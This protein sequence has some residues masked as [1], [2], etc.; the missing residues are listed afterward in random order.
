MYM[1][2]KGASVRTKVRVR[3]PLP[4]AFPHEAEREAQALLAREA[5]IMERESAAGG[6]R[7]FR[8][9]PTITIDPKSAKDFDDAISLR[10]LPDG[11]H[12]VGIHIADV[13]FFVSP[14]SALDKEAHKRATSIYLVD[15]VIPM[16]PEA[17]SNT[18]CSLLPH[19]ERLC[20]SAVFETS[21]DGSITKEWFGRSI[22]RSAARLTYEEAQEIMD[23]NGGPWGEMLGTLARITR[24]LRK[25][26]FDAGAIAI[27]DTELRCE[28]DADGKPLSFY[29]V[30]H[31]ESHQLIE[32]L[33]LL[34]N[35]RVAEF[36]SRAAQNKPGAFVY[37]IHDVPDT[38]KI[39][40]LDLYA[41]PMGY[42]ILRGKQV[43]PA[44]L[45]RLLIEVLGTPQQYFVHSATLR[46]MAK[47]IYS[48]KN[49]GHFG[50]AFKHYTHF[51]SPIRRY[52]D[53]LVHRLLTEY[54]KG[55]RVSAKLLQHCDRAA[56]HATER[57]VFAAEA[58]RDSL[59][60]KQVEYLAEHIGM[61]SN[62]I[63]TGVTNF[64]VFVR[65]ESTGADGLIHV[66]KL[67]DDYYV[68]NEQSMLLVG[69]HSKRAYRLGDTVSIRVCRVDTGKNQID[70]EL[71]P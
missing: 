55:R 27:H 38:E 50:L 29:V 13:S 43:N 26:K 34:A 63:I 57:E 1:V 5:E 67:P 49:I 64:G 68:F 32:D 21:K 60:A 40:F 12:E 59:K 53:L 39:A 42:S 37:R 8:N 56:L 30:P 61:E 9:V 33:M 11:T 15:R 14:E 2:K 20:Y 24:A 44:E 16:L 17:L 51:T 23:G 10:A 65:E 31:S 52:P 22:I 25:K 6:R 62:G 58:E 66:T 19:K 4:G 18:L 36:A 70:Y 48:M 54:L 7:D 3:P 45:N 41:R 47:A 28:L 69:E 46:A 71:V 35:R